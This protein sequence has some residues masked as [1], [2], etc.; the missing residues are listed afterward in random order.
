MPT[1][2]EIPTGHEALI[3]VSFSAISENAVDII[4][5]AT[6]GVLRNFNSWYG[7]GGNWS[8]GVNTSPHI[9]LIVIDGKHKKR[10]TGR[11]PWIQSAERVLYEDR[12]RK[13]TVI[14]YE[15]GDDGDY[16]DATAN[17]TVQPPTPIEARASRGRGR[18]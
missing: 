16:N 9:R 1:Q 14:G 17:V 6:G 2:I 7:G 12:R 10:S 15:D 11:D 5:H 18:R 8:S 13:R 4:E 3:Q